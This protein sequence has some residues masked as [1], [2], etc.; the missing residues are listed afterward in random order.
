MKRLAGK[1]PLIAI[2]VMAAVTAFAVVA[3]LMNIAERK[4]E[5][6]QPSL[7]VVDLERAS[8][9]TSAGLMKWGPRPVIVVFRSI[10]LHGCVRLRVRWTASSTSLKPEP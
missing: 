7:R 10:E 5:A 9:H 2:A 4:Q 8:S 6:R 1:G 3:L